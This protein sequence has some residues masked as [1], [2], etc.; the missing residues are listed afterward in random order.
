M[1]INAHIMEGYNNRLVL[2]RSTQSVDSSLKHID[3]ACRL[4][5]SGVCGTVCAEKH[6]KTLTPRGQ[7]SRNSD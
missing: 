2:T 7:L 3:Q 1:H 5:M 6:S 4:D